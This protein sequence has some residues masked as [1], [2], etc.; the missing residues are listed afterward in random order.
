MRSRGGRRSDRGNAIEVVGDTQLA[1]EQSG[2]SRTV[3]APQENQSRHGPSAFG[4]QYLVTA[5]HV[6]DETREVR[7]GVVNVDLAGLH[8]ELSLV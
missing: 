7:L 4:D 3:V 6:F 8:N 2:L 1:L 5:S